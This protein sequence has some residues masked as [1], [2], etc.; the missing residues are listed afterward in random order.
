MPQSVKKFVESC[1]TCQRI[2]HSMQKPYGLLNPIPPPEDKFDT[3]TMDF[4][5][6]LPPTKNGFDGTL[7]IIDAL[8]K[9][10]TFEPIKFTYSVEDIAKI[11]IRRIISCQGLPRKIISDQDPRFSGQFWKAI[12]KMLGTQIALSTV[13]HPQSNGQTE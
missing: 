9:A 1:D 10:A 8:T 7:I 2:K 12:F 11:F 6:L 3:Y 5:G 13:F 4:I